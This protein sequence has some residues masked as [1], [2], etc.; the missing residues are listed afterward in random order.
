MT[1]TEVKFSYHIS[2]TEASSG[3]NPHF[4]GTVQCLKYKILLPSLTSS[5]IIYYCCFEEG[6][7]NKT[8]LAEK[9][10]KMCYF[11]LNILSICK[12]LLSYSAF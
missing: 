11:L 3:Q 2:G 7:Q 8:L 4:R 12:G 10:L 5:S 1:C 6:K 9:K